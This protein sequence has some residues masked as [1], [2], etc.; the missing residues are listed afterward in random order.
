[1]T[2]ITPQ[3]VVDSFKSAFG[4]EPA[5]VTR[6]PGRVNLLGAHIDYSEGW[7]L[8]AAIDRSAWV[9]AAPSGGNEAVIEAL[10]FG[11]RAGFRLDELSL[12]TSEQ[13]DNPAWLRYPMGVAW[14]LREVRQS[15][16][17]MK[18]VLT[19]DVP[20]GAGVSSSAAVEMAYLLAW[21]QLSGFQLDNL[22]RAQLGQRA[23]NDFLGVGSGLMDQF[24]SVNGRS[25]HAVLLDCRHLTHE[26]VPLPEKTAVLLVDSGVRR[27]LA[28]INYNSRPDQCRKAA[29]ILQQHLPQLRTLRDLSYADFERY[30]HHLPMELR[31]RARHVVEECARVQAGAAAL[32]R[33]DVDHFGQLV[34]QSQL[35]SRDNYENS[36]PE[37]DVLAAAAWSVE[38]CYGSRFGGGGFGGFMQVL[39]REEAITAVS[40]HIATTFEKAF[41]RTPPMF[42]CQIGDGAEVF[43]NI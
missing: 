13:A 28:K 16:V 20:M 41:G 36:I 37:L 9:A 35:S 30:S 1:M 29:A 38:G 11:E 23:E 10:D 25:N 12:A 22:A 40:D 4:H 7:V 15:P 39:V 24:A 19:S 21:E 18:A 8:P 17:G 43:D 42:T 26:W 6:A 31:R 5:V 33:G 2:K 14:A 32:K 3:K 34:R 27:Q